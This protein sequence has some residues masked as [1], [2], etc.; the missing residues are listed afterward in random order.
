MR[1]PTLSLRWRLVLSSW[2]L[3]LAT[4][5]VFTLLFH[6]RTERQLLQQLE[7]TLRTRLDEVALVLGSGASYPTLEEFLLIETKNADTY[8]YDVRDVQGRVLARSSN[9]GGIGLPWPEDWRAG[10]AV[11]AT[12]IRTVPHP[13]SPGID[14]IRLLSERSRLSPARGEPFAVVIQTGVSLAPFESTV[15]QTLREAL[16]IAIGSLAGVFFLLWFVTDRALQPVAAMTRK[17]SQ[18]T[19]TN[20]RERLPHAGRGDELDELARV[21]NEMLDRLGGS[22]RQMEQF[23]SDAA[24]QLRT[25]LTRIRGELD[26]V[27]RSALSDTSR[28]ELE[29]VREDLV[30]MSRLCARLLLL[31]RLDQQAGITD[32]FEE[33]V[34]I[35]E[36]V[37][38]VLE[39]VSPLA[40]DHGIVLQRQAPSP[41][42]VR[43]SRRLLVEALLNLLDNAIR[44][45]PQGGRVAVSTRANGEVQL[46]VEDTGPGIPAEERARV[47]QRFYRLPRSAAGASDGGTGLGLAIVL[48]IAQA[49]GGRVELEDAPAGGALFRLVLPR[50]PS[51][52]EHLPSRAHEVLIPG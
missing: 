29:R 37:S 30:D 25:P 44:C 15:R 22:L 32:L 31:A 10:D 20:L 51:P 39:Q 13:I 48:G 40:L 49:H 52:D 24:H 28:S 16:V 2:S 17:A 12:S 45:T 23:S 4:A 5:V 14:R 19:A 21:V 43:G 50:E 46:C 26:L 11:A 9:L 8:F 3:A 38:D 27:L 18:I 41:V 36:V 35:G 1:K 47:F 7:R 34:D 6:L 33:R 42:R